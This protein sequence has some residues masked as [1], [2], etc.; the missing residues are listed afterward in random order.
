MPLIST[1]ADYL[2]AIHIT[3]GKRISRYPVSTLRILQ[4]RFRYGI[5]PRLFSLFG[6]M[7]QKREKWGD[8]LVDENLRVILRRINPSSRRKAASDKLAFYEHCLAH[9]L[10][11]IPVLC[12]IDNRPPEGQLSELAISSAE[13]WAVRLQHCREALFIKLIDGTWG[14]D[15]FWAEPTGEGWRFC[16]HQ[17]SCEDLYKFVTRRFEG[18][19][20][21]IVQPKIRSHPDLERISAPG[22]LTTLRALTCMVDGTPRVFFAVLRI[23]VGDN[24]TDHFAHG[25]SGNIVAPVDT[26]TGRIGSCRG[27]INKTWPEVV[28]VSNHPDTG[29]SIQGSQVPMW[30]EVL[31]LIDRGQ[32]SFPYLKTLGWDI[33]VTESGP[34]LVEANPTYD[35]DSV[36]V[37]HQ[38]GIGDVLTPWLEGNG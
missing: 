4:S 14:K 36:Q 1:V 38:R 18:K 29:N 7:G 8:Y 25:E 37:S 10:D 3:S 17:G 26:E 23:P 9:G 22:A 32:R 15:A 27:S 31:K 30:D 12:A 13:E 16:G 33:A 35:V 21:C 24:V 19:R 11:T 2:K 5:G 6:L 34:V 20:G 28:D